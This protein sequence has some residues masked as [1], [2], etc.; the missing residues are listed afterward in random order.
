MHQGSILLEPQIF[1]ICGL[2][3]A[4]SIAEATMCK[5][6]GFI[7]ADVKGSI[8]SDTPSCKQANSG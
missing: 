3:A 4:E 2:G 7:F 1:A 6:L 5:N 8:R